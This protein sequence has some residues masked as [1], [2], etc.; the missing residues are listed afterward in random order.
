M[1]WKKILLSSSDRATAA[2]KE[3]FRNKAFIPLAR[4]TVSDFCKAAAAEA[5]G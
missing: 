2:E 5:A 4:K 1:A 3:M